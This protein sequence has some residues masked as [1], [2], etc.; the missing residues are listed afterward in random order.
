MKRKNIIVLSVILLI[1]LLVLIVTIIIFKND[2]KLKYNESWLNKNVTIKI[3]NKLG[4]NIYEVKKDSEIDIYN[5]V[6]QTV[7]N[8]KINKLNNDD[9]SFDNPLIIYNAY[10]TNNYSLN[11]YFAE[12]EGYHVSY[13]IASDGNANF[14]K[15]LLNANNVQ[16]GNYAYQIIG[17][18]PGKENKIT[19]NLKDQDNNLIRTNELIINTPSLSKKAPINLTITNNQSPSKLSDGLYTMLGYDNYSDVYLYDNDGTLR[20][21]IPVNSYRTDKIIQLENEL[22]Y[23]YSEKDF[24]LVNNLGM[25][26]KTYHIKDYS[27]HHDFIYDEENEKIITLVDEDN[28]DTIED[29]V[30]EYDIKTNTQKV[31][32]DMKNYINDFYEKAIVPEDGNT[33]GGDELDWVHLNAIDFTNDGIIVSSRELS[34]LIAFKN[35]YDNPSIKYVIGDKALLKDSSLEKYS[36]TKKG[37]FTS[38]AGQHSVQFFDNE[39]DAD[40]TYYLIIYNNNYGE[41]QTRTDFDW[42]GFEGVGSYNDGEKSMYYKY[43]VNEKDKTYELVDKIDTDYSSIVSNIQILSDNILISSGKNKSFSEYDEEGKLIRKYS[44]DAERFTYRIMK[45]DFKNFL[46]E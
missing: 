23:N 18:V 38:Q 33:Y 3:N 27:M 20:G 11:I 2:G 39:N 31:L 4:K 29:I 25:V 6:Y 13:T 22:L 12:E 41:S 9:Y 32:I 10:G 8:N 5:E 44:Y 34:T 17:L 19:L 14:T 36:Y 16:D 37:N 26:T 30:L 42:S 45:Y 35:I 1:T 7:V 43:L 24:A 40:E 46:F 28:G 21:Q 15:S